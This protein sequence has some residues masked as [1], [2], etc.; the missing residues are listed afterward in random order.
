MM[1]INQIVTLLNAGFTA[2]EIRALQSR[3]I[4]APE[5]E[6]EPTP[7]PSPAPS[8][9]PAPD[10]YAEVLSAISAL[11]AAIQANGIANSNQPKPAHSREDILASII[12]PTK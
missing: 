6:P 10:Q 2:D 7:A 1:D 12:K 9:A 11:T 4:P 3:D 8:P 5:P